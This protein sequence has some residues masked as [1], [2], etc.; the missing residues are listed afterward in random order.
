[1][2]YTI[3]SREPVMRG[4]TLDGR[5]VTVSKLRLTAPG[6][7]GS[8]EQYAVDVSEGPDSPAVAYGFNSLDDAERFMQSAKAEDYE[9]H[10]RNGNPTKATRRGLGVPEGMKQDLRDA[11]VQKPKARLQA[12]PPADPP[13]DA[14][15][16]PSTQQEQTATR[17]PGSG[18]TE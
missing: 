18:K 16:P 8:T 9:S 10:D 13:A 14:G 17:Q 1:M 2:S 12:I 15:K 4:M 11:P 7:N 6:P 5:Q 3:A